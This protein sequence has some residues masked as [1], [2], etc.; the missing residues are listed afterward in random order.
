MT[1]RRAVPSEDKVAAECAKWIRNQEAAEIGTGA[2]SF[3]SG[4]A[5]GLAGNIVVS[6]MFATSDASRRLEY[7]LYFAAALGLGGIAWLLLRMAYWT[8]CLKTAPMRARD[9]IVPR[10][11]LEDG[12]IPPSDEELDLLQVAVEASI[13][14]TIRTR[15]RALLPWA[16]VSVGVVVVASVIGIVAR[17]P[18]VD[19]APRSSDGVRSCCCIATEKSRTPLPMPREAGPA[20]VAEP[21]ER[22]TRKRDSV[23]PESPR[24]GSRGTE[25][26]SEMPAGSTKRLSPATVPLPTLPPAETKRE[27][28]TG[29]AWH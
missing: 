24:S 16:F 8:D 26:R 18:G 23:T 9:Q 12:E 17:R 1:S 14:E 27:K 5:T 3:L 6:I 20:A 13:R 7:G 11:S 2:L 29:G 15:F 4:V 19:P 10:L 22:E 21:A 25:R 28:P